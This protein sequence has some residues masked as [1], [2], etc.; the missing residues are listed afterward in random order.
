VLSW[1]AHL[2]LSAYLLVIAAIASLLG[3]AGGVIWSAAAG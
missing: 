1:V 2:S 3:V